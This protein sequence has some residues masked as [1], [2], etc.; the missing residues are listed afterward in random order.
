MNADEVM[1][2]ILEEKEKQGI[3]IG[4]LARRTGSY[5]SN[6]EHWIHGGGITLEKADRVLKALGISVEI[7]KE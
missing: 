5:P 6:V 7:G 3:S 1:K 4:E 2:R